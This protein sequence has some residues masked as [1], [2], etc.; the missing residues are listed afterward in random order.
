MNQAAEEP[1]LIVE[2]DEPAWHSEHPLFWRWFGYYWLRIRY[3]LWNHGGYELF[4]NVG[5]RRWAPVRKWWIRWCNPGH[6]A[7]CEFCGYNWDWGDNDGWFRCE[8]SGSYNGGDHTVHWFEG[9]QAC[10]RCRSTWTYGDS[11]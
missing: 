2:G 5:S 10:P 7:P 11:D 6:G 1:D 9:E 3:W 4:W 8:S